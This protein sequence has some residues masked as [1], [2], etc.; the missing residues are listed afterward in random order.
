MQ[1]QGLIRLFHKT[2]IRSYFPFRVR[3]IIF[4]QRSDMLLLYW[5]LYRN[6]DTI[7]SLQT[8]VMAVLICI[9]VF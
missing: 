5:V 7:I 9:C 1:L 3:I 6:C 8:V 4:F 2:L